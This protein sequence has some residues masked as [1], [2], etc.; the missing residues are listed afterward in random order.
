MI[1]NKG[2][3]IV[4]S[5]P[6]GAGKTSIVQYVLKR[7]ENLEFSIS[8]TTRA[9]RES[10]THGKDYYFITEEDFKRKIEANEFIEWE[11]FYD[12]YYGT[13]KS[14]V[15]SAVNSGKS[16]L[17]EVDVKGAISIKK[18]YPQAILIFIAPPSF[19]ILKKRLINR[20]TESD[21]DLRKRIERVEMELAFEKHFDFVVVNDNLTKARSET[22][23]IIKKEINRSN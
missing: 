19:E 15:D 6:S 2:K 17:L 14:S 21:E 13:L 1:S 22:L 9:K 3:I 12:Y 4:V 18:D 5:A 11:C 23:E 8:A 10:E 20:K 16:V 7:V